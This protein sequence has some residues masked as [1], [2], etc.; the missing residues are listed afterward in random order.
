M[1]VAKLG[2]M[3]GRN[4]DVDIDISNKDGRK[5]EEALV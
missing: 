3:K 2:A 5:R 4:A 1:E